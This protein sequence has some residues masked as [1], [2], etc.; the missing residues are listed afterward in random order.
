MNTNP[1][2]QDGAW[3]NRREELIGGETVMMPPASTNHNRITR[4]ISRI[5]SNYLHGRRCEPFSDG[6]AVYLTEEDRFI[7]DFMIVCDPA[8]IQWDGVHGA[9][10]L[11]VEV[12]SPGTAKNDRCR[13][14]EC[15]EACGV[16]EYW[17][18]NPGEHSI[19]VY[20]AG[21]KGFVLHDI[22]TLFPDW[23]LARMNETER[24]SVSTHFKCSLFNDLD[25]SL[26]DIFYRT[27]ETN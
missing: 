20:L 15:Y 17:L 1:A 5:F 23:Q 6:E 27:F 18:I 14:R 10:D 4:N 3:E 25:I 13:K 9:P 2:Y 26:A 22:H 11:V 7:P 12:L 24:A 21:K 19:E 16:R 8:K